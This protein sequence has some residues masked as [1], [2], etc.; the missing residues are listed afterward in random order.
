MAFG[1]VGV[2]MRWRTRPGRAWVMT[3]LVLAAGLL[4]AFSQMGRG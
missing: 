2:G 1:L 3:A 4:Y